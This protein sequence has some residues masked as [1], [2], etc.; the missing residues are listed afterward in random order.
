M[1]VGV[2]LTPSPASVVYVI[3]FKAITMAGEEA[4][5]SIYFFSPN[6]KIYQP[7]ISDSYKAAF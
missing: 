1:C 7:N 2:W 5:F 4:G 3:T 6:G